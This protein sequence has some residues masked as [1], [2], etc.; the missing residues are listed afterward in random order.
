MSLQ[1]RTSVG[2]R[3]FR[4]WLM[5]E[6]TGLMEQL[7]VNEGTVDLCVDVMLTALI[8]PHVQN[9]STPYA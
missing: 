3:G 7:D 9:P 1:A 2:L 4:L 5:T 6:R 8:T